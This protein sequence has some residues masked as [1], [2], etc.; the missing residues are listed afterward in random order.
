MKL[1]WPMFPALLLQIAK[2]FRLL[3]KHRGMEYFP[4]SGGA[5]C[6]PDF[7][8]Q[9]LTTHC[10]TRKALWED[11]VN[12]LAAL[13]AGEGGVQMH[14]GGFTTG[15]IVACLK[16][17]LQLGRQMHGLAR[18][19]M[20]LLVPDEDEFV[21]TK[22]HEIGALLLPRCRLYRAR[23]AYHEILIEHTAVRD[24]AMARVRAFLEETRREE[25]GGAGAGQGEGEAEAPTGEGSGAGRSRARSKSPARRSK[26]SAGAGAVAPQ[27]SALVQLYIKLYVTVRGALRSEAGLYAVLA[28]CVAAAYARK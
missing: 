10:P 14:V 20:L 23:G 7:R 28:A 26:T 19:P 5:D 3:S 11:K 17:V 21:C 13:P 24:K 9:S 12:R 18:V 8:S 15:W 22:A 27:P 4:P 1:P 25:E 6:P 2:L 16:A